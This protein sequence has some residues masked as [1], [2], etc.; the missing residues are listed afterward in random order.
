MHKFLVTDE[1]IDRL[2]KIVG[3]K[4]LRGGNKIINE[5]LDI[6]EKD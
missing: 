2:E 3:Y 4:I 5:A 6:L 1:T